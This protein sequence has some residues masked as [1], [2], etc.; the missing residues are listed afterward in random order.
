[1]ARSETGTQTGQA[2]GLNI[3]QL[4]APARHTPNTPV[5]LRP[6]ADRV[7]NRPK[8]QAR[9]TRRDRERIV[10]LDEQGW[11]GSRIAA[12]LNIEVNRL[13]ES[14]TVQGGGPPTAPCV[15]TPRLGLSMATERSASSCRAAES[16]DFA[17]TCTTSA[18]L[19]TVRRLA[20]S[21]L[22]FQSIDS[23]LVVGSETPNAL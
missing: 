23:C 1:M 13:R 18:R 5:E 7:Q 6:P 11:S 10:K 22:C 3:D 15:L 12:H 8:A 21:D 2:D 16:P 9:I 19:A 20:C 4:V 14:P 17:S